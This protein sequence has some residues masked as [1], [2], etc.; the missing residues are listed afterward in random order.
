MEVSGRSPS[1]RQ[2]S[3][4]GCRSTEGKE[5]EEEEEEEEEREGGGHKQR[6]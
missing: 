3:G 1:R 5:K 6:T 2:R 4:L